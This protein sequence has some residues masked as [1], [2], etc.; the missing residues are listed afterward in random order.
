M[1]QQKKPCGN[2]CG[3]SPYPPDTGTPGALLGTDQLG[4]AGMD[5]LHAVVQHLY[6]ND[7]TL[8]L[9]GCRALTSPACLYV[10][11]NHGIVRAEMVRALA[12]AH[13]RTPLAGRL[14]EILSSTEQEELRVA[15]NLATARAASAR[16]QTKESDLHDAD[17]PA[18]CHRR[19][20]NN[21]GPIATCLVSEAWHTADVHGAGHG[22]T[23]GALAVCAFGQKRQRHAVAHRLSLPARPANARPLPPYCVLHGLQVCK[24]CKVATYCSA[25]CKRAEKLGD[26]ATCHLNRIQ[27]GEPLRRPQAAFLTALLVGGLERLHMIDNASGHGLLQ[28]VCG[29]MASGAIGCAAKCA[30]HKGLQFVQAPP[31]VNCEWERVHAAPPNF[32]ACC[33]ECSSHPSLTCERQERQNS[34]ARNPRITPPLRARAAVMPCCL[35]HTHDTAS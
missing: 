5:S 8:Q 6:S 29:R 23:A 1:C 12:A 24:V 10:G 2:L 32:H 30:M 17:L 27:R 20:C 11:G 19:G 25:E 28:A 26:H 35:C 21:V 3:S 34:A 33:L 14:V 7:H 9:E 22:S 4:Y 13:H 16:K 31:A 15:A 18:R